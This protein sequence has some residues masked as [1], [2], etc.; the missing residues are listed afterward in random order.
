LRFVAGGIAPAQ[1][2]RTVAGAPDKITS[3]FGGNFFIPRN[4]SEASIFGLLEIK[5]PACAGCF[6]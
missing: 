6:L 2:A 3:A 5:N 1:Q 4:S